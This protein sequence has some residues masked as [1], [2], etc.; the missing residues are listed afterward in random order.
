[1]E[2]LSSVL[3]NGDEWWVGLS[4]EMMFSFPPSVTTGGKCWRRIGD[5]T[6]SSSSLTSCLIYENLCLLCQEVVY[7]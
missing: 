7:H 6:S 1:M 3:F 4:N 5:A 2:S